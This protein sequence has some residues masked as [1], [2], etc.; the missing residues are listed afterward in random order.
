VPAICRYDLVVP[1][2]AVDENGHVNNVEYLRWMQDAANRHSGVQGCTRITEQIGATWFVRSHHIEY[3]HPAF[4]GEPVA[5]LTW[6]SNFRR[7]FSLRKFRVFRVSDNALLAAAE[8]EYVFVDAAGGR[9]RS[10]PP[11]VAGLFEL[12]PAEAEPQ[13]L[14]AEPAHPLPT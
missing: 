6:V 13:R 7:V 11:E 10:I 5:V 3:L 1:E 9:P 8:T 2:A 4:A 14:G 12:V